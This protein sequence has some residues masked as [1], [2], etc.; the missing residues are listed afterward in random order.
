MAAQVTGSKLASGR[1][2]TGLATVLVAIGA[3][4]VGLSACGSGSSTSATG[5]TSS[6][7]K[8][9][10]G[11][12]NV[13]LDVANK[14]PETL[15]VFMCA[16]TNALGH[17]PCKSQGYLAKGE[18]THLTSE[19]VGG[20]IHFRGNTVEYRA[21]NPDVGDPSIRLWPTGSTD[22]A[23][24]QNQQNADQFN[25]SEGQ[26]VETNVGGHLFDM[27]RSND[28]DYKVMSLTVR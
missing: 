23:T 9:E 12:K 7:V 28:T 14:N 8:Q 20:Y 2:R 10:A 19:V 3:L 26:T 21:K 1:I 15:Y 5:S 6:V 11:Y 13:Q 22:K 17:G 4:V 27:A 16:D 25:L 18:S 24:N